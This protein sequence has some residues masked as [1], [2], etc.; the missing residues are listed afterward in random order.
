MVICIHIG[1]VTHCFE[2]ITIN[3]PFGPPVPGIGP[4]NYPQLFRDAT[5]VASVQSAALQI[6][7]AGVR[8]T[9]L[10]GVAASVAALQKR[11]GSYVTISNELQAGS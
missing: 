10:K 3:W 11:A 5:I 4:V 7:D 9:A 1:S 2:I 8:E 6:A